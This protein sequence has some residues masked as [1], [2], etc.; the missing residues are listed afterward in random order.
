[1]TAADHA[2]LILTAD[3][4][5]RRLVSVGTSSEAPSNVADAEGPWRFAPSVFSCFLP[6]GNGTSA[7]LQISR[8]PGERFS[9]DAERVTRVAARVLQCWLVGAQPF[10]TMSRPALRGLSSRNSAPHRRGAR[11]RDAVRCS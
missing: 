7:T 3:G 10:C 8:L 11:T 6:L 4:Q 1:M 2:S 5:Q 9:P